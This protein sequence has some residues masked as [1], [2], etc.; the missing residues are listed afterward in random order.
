M[1]NNEKMIAMFQ[2][3]G[4]GGNKRSL[5]FEG[6]K[7]IYDCYDWNNFFIHQTDENDVPI[8]EDEQVLTDETGREL[9]NAEELKVALETGIGRI[10][11]DGDYDTVY[12]TYAEDL[13]ENELLAMINPGRGF[14]Y[15]EEELHQAL[16]QY[17][18]DEVAVTLAEKADDIETLITDTLGGFNYIKDNFEEVS[19]DDEFDFTI[20]K[21]DN[22]FYKKI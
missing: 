6:F 14:H 7:K 17:G 3:K 15:L 2:I 21:V 1:E 4:G 8:P 20:Y 18:I 16:L 10:E 5:Q 22:K 12:T 13:D 11:I 19:E 9:M